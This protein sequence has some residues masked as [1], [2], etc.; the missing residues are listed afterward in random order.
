MIVRKY[1]VVDEEGKVIK[2][3]V[4]PNQN[5]LVKIEKSEIHLALSTRK[6]LNTIISDVNVFMEGN[7]INKLEIEEEEGGL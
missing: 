1:K 4:Y 5:N 3:T 7:T 2:F 6:M